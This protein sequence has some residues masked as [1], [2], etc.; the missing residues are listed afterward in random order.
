[1]PWMLPTGQPEAPGA[2]DWGGRLSTDNS[3]DAQ[4]FAWCPT[5]VSQTGTNAN[6]QT[7]GGNNWLGFSN[8]EM[9]RI[10]TSLQKPMSQAQVTKAYAAAEKII[11]NEALSLAIFQHPAATAH[12]ATLKNVKPSPLSPNLV[13]NYWEWRY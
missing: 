1:M 10:L 9:D 12:N 2:A 11:I 3:Y 6:F 8:P 4:F 5:S 13:W 7:G